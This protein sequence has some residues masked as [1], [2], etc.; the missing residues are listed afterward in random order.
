MLYPTV[1]QVNST[2]DLYQDD[3]PV[4][5]YTITAAGKHANSMYAYWAMPNLAGAYWGIEETRFTGAP[6]LANP[7]A[8]RTIGG[9]K[10]QFYLDGSQIHLIAYVHHGIAYWLT[11]T[12]RDD[13]TNAEMIAIAKSL[14]P[15]P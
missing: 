11:N 1:S 13:L 14:K 4:R 15:V 8:V 2:F 12:L 6:I 7:D 10:L 5:T 9:R 3:M